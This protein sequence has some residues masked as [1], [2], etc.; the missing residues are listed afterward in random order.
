[1]VIKLK[2][3]NFLFV[4]L[5]YLEFKLKKKRGGEEKIFLKEESKSKKERDC[6]L[7]CFFYK[8]KFKIYDINGLI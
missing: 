6:I 3:L 1:M 8:F 5:V 4:V 2:I 7:K